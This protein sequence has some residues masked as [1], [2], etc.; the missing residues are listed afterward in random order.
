VG[1]ECQLE[2]GNHKGLAWKEKKIGAEGKKGRA[3]GIEIVK[4]ECMRIQSFRNSPEFDTHF[5]PW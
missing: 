4:A 5:V 2:L 3:S 1:F